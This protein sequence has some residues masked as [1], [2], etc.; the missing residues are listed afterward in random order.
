MLCK[1]PKDY[2]IPQNHSLIA[3]LYIVHTSVFAAK[4]YQPYSSW[5]IAS[6]LLCHIIVKLKY[7][8]VNAVFYLKL[9]HKREE[10]E[11]YE[12]NTANQKPG[13]AEAVQRLL[14]NGKTQC[15]KLYPDHHGVKFRIANL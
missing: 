13:A 11:L 6:C 1:A 14:P 2:N 15:Q 5:Q 7:G 8:S 10:G 3:Q 9:L 4:G 12:Y